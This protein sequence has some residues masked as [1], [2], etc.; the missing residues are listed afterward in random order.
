MKG[1][2]RQWKDAMMQRERQRHVEETAGFRFGEFRLDLVREELVGPAGACVLRRKVF[3]TLRVLLEA[4]PAVVTLDELLDRVW[5][6]H[7][8]SASAIP[9]VIAELRRMLHDDAALPRYVETRHRRGYRMCAAVEHERAAVGA[10][11]LGTL[12]EAS[13]RAAGATPRQR[14]ERLQRVASERGLAFLAL[15]AKLSLQAHAGAETV[16]FFD[17]EDACG[18]AAM[19]SARPR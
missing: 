18:S 19:P 5:G 14:L 8:L 13:A 11:L 1:A 12:D 17:D 2:A 10:D 4:A 6:R 15:Q 3:D 7:A 9:N 16:L